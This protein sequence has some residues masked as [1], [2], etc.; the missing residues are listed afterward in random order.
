V[1]RLLV[2]G[3][4]SMLG[5]NL[6]LELAERCEVLGLYERA[7]LES[8]A[9]RTAEWQPDDSAALVAFVDEWQPQWIVRCG[10]LAASSWDDAPDGDVAGREPRVV[11]Q[12]AD[13]AERF[14][15]RLTVISSD[16]VFA[17]PRMF[18]DEA[19]AGASSAPRAAWVRQ[20]ERV[21]DDREALVVRTHAYGWSFA[22]APGFAERTFEAVASH[23]A[24]DVDGHRHATP[25]LATDLAELLWRGYETRLTGL[26]HLAGAER[27]SPHRFASELAAAMGAALV[28][29]PAGAGPA[30]AC[31]EETSLSSKRARRMLAAATP[32]LREGLARFV[33]QA[34]SGWRERW[35]AADA[36]R[37]SHAAA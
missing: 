16:A 4:D 6:A 37:L 3:I 33:A 8:P 20:M 32:T 35:Q 26:Y 5:A 2:C 29:E 31:Q 1:E 34:D 36:A 17:G 21:L 25:I 10:P 9:V 27:T 24:A 11:R 14:G 15:S 28:R 18:H 12:L 23:H 13:A 22:G 30:A 7:A 19:A